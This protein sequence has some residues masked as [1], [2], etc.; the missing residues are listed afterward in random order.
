MPNVT[1]Q[2]RKRLA[3]CDIAED[4]AIG[5]HRGSWRKLSVTL[6]RARQQAQCS[7]ARDKPAGERD[8]RQRVA[9]QTLASRLFLTSHRTRQL[10][11]YDVTDDEAVD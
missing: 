6:L 11:E 1:L 9:S 5:R 4:A 7:I 3:D 8:L 10:A 2:K